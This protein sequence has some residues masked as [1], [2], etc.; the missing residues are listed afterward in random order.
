[1]SKGEPAANIPHLVFPSVVFLQ[2]SASRSPEG[3]INLPNSSDSFFF[4]DNLFHFTRPDVDVLFRFSAL[5]FFLSFPHINSPHHRKLLFLSTE[6]QEDKRYKKIIKINP[7][8]MWESVR[9][10]TR[11]Q[12]A[13][14]RQA[15]FSPLGSIG[16]P[17]GGKSVYRDSFFR[18][19][20]T[21]CDVN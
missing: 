21:Q 9:P 12:K 15:G 5:S 3:R 18:V 17:A 10:R 2:R 16:E 20:S 14:R 4:F 6:E 7:S 8:W 11:K 19:Q 1:M 13:R